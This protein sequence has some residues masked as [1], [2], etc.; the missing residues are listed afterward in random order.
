MATILRSASPGPLRLFDDDERAFPEHNPIERERRPSGAENGMRMRAGEET[1]NRFVQ[2]IAV[3]SPLRTA[4]PVQPAR[5]GS[6]RPQL[7]RHD[8]RRPVDDNGASSAPL[9]EGAC[10]PFLCE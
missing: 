5:G 4:S 8:H 3:W 9:S 6:R 10:L 1:A 7:A 2:K